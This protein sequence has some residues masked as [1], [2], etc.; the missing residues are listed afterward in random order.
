MNIYE[1]MVILNAAISDEEAD[2]AINKDQG[3]DYRPGRR[4]A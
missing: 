1:N 3:T 4:S 2:A